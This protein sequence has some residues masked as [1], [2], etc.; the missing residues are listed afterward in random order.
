MLHGEVTLQASLR[1]LLPYLKSAAALLTS[2]LPP[3]AVIVVFWLPSRCHEATTTKAPL[4][5]STT[6]V[7]RNAY[8]IGTV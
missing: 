7:R 4:S 6:P 8:Y 2:F 1:Q 5:Q 3:L